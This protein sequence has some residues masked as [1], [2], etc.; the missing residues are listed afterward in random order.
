MR[1]NYNFPSF[2][3]QTL[4][5]TKFVDRSELSIPTV[6]CNDGDMGIFTISLQLPHGDGSIMLWDRPISRNRESC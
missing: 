4:L 3:T 5:G 6:K 1:P 2:K